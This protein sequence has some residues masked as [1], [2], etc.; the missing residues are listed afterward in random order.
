MAK[1][2]KSLDEQER[3]LKEQLAD[4]E[5]KKQ[6]IVDDK[7]RVIGEAVWAEMQRNEEFSQS[8]M[9]VVDS[10]ISK[11]ADRALFELA[12][13]ERKSTKQNGGDVVGNG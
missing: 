12:K 13:R 2:T 10:N 11:N 3:I 5:E 4:I 8:I 1:S 7:K 9:N 6:R